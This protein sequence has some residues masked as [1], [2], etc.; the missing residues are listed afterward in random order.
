[1]TPKAVR[2][3]I[4]G[5]V[6]VQLYGEE[7]NLHA[8]RVS[9]RVLMEK[10]WLRD[11]G[12]DHGEGTDIQVSTDRRRFHRVEPGYWRDLWKMDKSLHRHGHKG[13]DQDVLGEPNSFSTSARRYLSDG[14][15]LS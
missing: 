11:W 3:M 4:N 1:M 6:L 12:S 2:P 10:L 7:S 9:S 5:N 15:D 8:T 14:S 13:L